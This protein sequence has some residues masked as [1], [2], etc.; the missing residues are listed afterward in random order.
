MPWSWASCNIFIFYFCCARKHL[1][2]VAVDWILFM[3]HMSIFHKL[4]MV[5]I[6]LKDTSVTY[7]SQN[8]PRIKQH[9]IIARQLEEQLKPHGFRTSEPENNRIFWSIFF[10][11]G[12]EMQD[13]LPNICLDWF[14]AVYPTNECECVSGVEDNSIRAHVNVCVCMF[15]C[16]MHQTSIKL[17][18][19]DVNFPG[20]W[21]A[22]QH[23]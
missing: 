16:A 7:L 21:E 10:I 9:Y 14:V 15:V 17:Q 5:L 2:L 6:R 23:V 8:T 12:D 20:Y 18:W 1:H 22:E 3:R 11:L 19:D 4:K 13:K